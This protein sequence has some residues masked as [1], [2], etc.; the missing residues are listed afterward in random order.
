LPGV[1]ANDDSPGNLLDR[2][3]RQPLKPKAKG[4]PIMKRDI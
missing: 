3:T 1:L 4:E 2:E